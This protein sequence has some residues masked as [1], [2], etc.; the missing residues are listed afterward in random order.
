MSVTNYPLYWDWYVYIAELL[1]NNTNTMKRFILKELSQGSF[2][3]ETSNSTKIKDAKL[4]VLKED[5]ENSL[6]KWRKDFAVI[7]EVYMKD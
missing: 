3:T 2:L 5:A 4:F 6:L 1:I 7:I